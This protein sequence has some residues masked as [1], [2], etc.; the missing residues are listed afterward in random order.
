MDR[1]A[2]AAAELMPL[3]AR[4]DDDQQRADGVRRAGLDRAEQIRRDGSAA[5]AA[6]R[7]RAAENAES[8][9]AQA[10]AEVLGS[11]ATPGEGAAPDTAEIARRAAE[12]LPGEVERVVAVARELIAQLCAPIPEAADR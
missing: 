5:A 7:A 11:A 12:R 4:L 10:E 6:V 2:A 1:A 8:V 9:A 3:L